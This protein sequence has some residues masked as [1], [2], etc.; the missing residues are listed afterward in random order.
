[1][2]QLDFPF[3]FLKCAR[4]YPSAVMSVRRSAFSHRSYL[5]YSENIFA[6][7][8]RLQDGN[9]IYCRKM[10]NFQHSKPRCSRNPGFYVIG[11]QRRLKDILYGIILLKLTIVKSAATMR[12]VRRDLFHV[13]AVFF[14]IIN[15][16]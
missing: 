6:K 12:A 3:I 15:V 10:E 5:L 7:Y 1:M 2:N 8:T 4:D 11:Q 13:L 14:V 16:T 9:C